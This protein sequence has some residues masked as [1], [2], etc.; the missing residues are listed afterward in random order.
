LNAGRGGGGE[1]AGKGIGK[2]LREGTVKRKNLKEEI[3]IN[4][5][6]RGIKEAMN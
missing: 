6:E 4:E 3:S 1:I 2:A 5:R